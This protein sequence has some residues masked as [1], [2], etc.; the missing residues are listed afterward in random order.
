MN[1]PDL[2][3]WIEKE[4]EITLSNFDSET[5]EL[6][7]V[8]KEIQNSNINKEEIFILARTNRQLN[9]LSRLMKEKNIPHII[10]SE[11]EKSLLTAK[12]GEITLATIHAI[13]GLEAKTVF[14]I[15][16]NEQNF[17]C[18]ASDHPIIEMI[19]IEEYDK[20]E[21]EKRLF[22]VALSR[23]KEKLYITNGR[24]NFTRF[25]TDKMK[26]LIE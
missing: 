10:R 20:E 2:N 24:G 19:K 16:S 17:P 4:G 21:E 6:N 23:A 14:I 3:H 5:E 13:K 15:G 18:K 11:E 22:Y 7:F 1:L 9:T 25:L 26:G 12:Q 8:I